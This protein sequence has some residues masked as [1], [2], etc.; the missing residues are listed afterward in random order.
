MLCMQCNITVYNAML[1][2][3]LC[4][5]HII[6]LI[7]HHSIEMAILLLL[8]VPLTVASPLRST[9]R[10]LIDCIYDHNPQT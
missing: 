10:S 2:S 5:N 1:S 8:T 7:G 9:H 6:F 4:N 3:F